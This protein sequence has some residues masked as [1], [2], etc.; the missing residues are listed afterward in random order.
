MNREGY[1]KISVLFIDCQFSVHADLQVKNKL[2]VIEF[3]EY[4]N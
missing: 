1:L 3:Y 2:V 4:V